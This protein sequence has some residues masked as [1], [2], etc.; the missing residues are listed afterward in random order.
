MSDFRCNDLRL[1]TGIAYA[2]VDE[3]RIVLAPWTS[4]PPK[5]CRF[6]E[7]NLP[8]ATVLTLEIDGARH[9]RGGK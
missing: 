9:K 8:F 1:Q 5:F 4:V 6:G 2:D 3:R 7:P